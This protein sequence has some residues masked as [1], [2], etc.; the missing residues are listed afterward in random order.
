MKRIIRKSKDVDIQIQSSRKQVRIQCV[1]FV[2]LLCMIIC[3]I[4]LVTASDDNVGK[5]KSLYSIF[6]LILILFCFDLYRIDWSLK[7]KNHILFIKKWIF[8]YEIPFRDLIDIKDDWWWSDSFKREFLDIK[9]KKGNKMKFLKIDY[10]WK[11]P[12]LKFEYMNK[13]KITEFI[14]IFF[15]CGELIDDKKENNILLPD[16]KNIRTKEEEKELDDWLNKRNN[17]EEKIIWLCICILSIG[18]IAFLWY[19]FKIN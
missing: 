16:Y 5:P 11:T 2:L 15:R 18:F 13:N 14:N 12:F 4:I 10:L 1:F 8:K 7:T 19:I 6:I 17:N 9:Y 3:S